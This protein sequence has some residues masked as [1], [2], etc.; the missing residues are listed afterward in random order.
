MG[1]IKTEDD[2]LNG[3]AQENVITNHT[4]ILKVHHSL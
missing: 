3:L 2:P 1:M 4:S